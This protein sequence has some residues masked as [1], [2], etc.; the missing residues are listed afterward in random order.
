VVQSLDRH[1]P[2]IGQ[3]ERDGLQVEC[4]WR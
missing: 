4:S 1:L 3:V 2:S